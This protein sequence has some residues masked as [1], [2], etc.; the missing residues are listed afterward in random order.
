VPAN[1][2]ILTLLPRSPELNPVENV[3]LFLRDNW[4]SNR[5]F[6]SYDDIVDHCC[7]AWNKLIQQPWKIMS[8]RTI[9]HCRPHAQVSFRARTLPLGGTRSGTRCVL[10][11]WLFPIYRPVD[12]FSRTFFLAPGFLI[13]VVLASIAGVT[14]VTRSAPG[15]GTT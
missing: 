9:P 12:T 15:E 6:S 13:V 14:F 4:L 5:V 10:V 2:S 11:F 8:N 7:E 3:W 1:I